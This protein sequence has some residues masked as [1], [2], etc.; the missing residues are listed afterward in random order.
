MRGK[1]DFIMK[2]DIV[3]SYLKKIFNVKLGETVLK[4][5]YDG[6]SRYFNDTL[7]PYNNGAPGKETVEYRMGEILYAPS[8]VRSSWVY[9]EVQGTNS[10]PVYYDVFE[11]PFTNGKIIVEGLNGFKKVSPGLSIM[12]VVFAKRKGERKYRVAMIDIMKVT[13]VDKPIQ[14]DRFSKM[15]L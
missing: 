15:Q 4:D 5:T 7:T 6:T 14:K 3:P 13:R 8:K 2:R 11:L 1:E 9:K 10:T 12:S